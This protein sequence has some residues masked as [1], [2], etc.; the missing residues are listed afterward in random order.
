MSVNEE[1]SIKESIAQII[2]RSR[3][4]DDHILT[5]CAHAAEE[6]FNIYIRDQNYLTQNETTL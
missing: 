6:I 5:D 4:M 3:Y 1:Q 2:E